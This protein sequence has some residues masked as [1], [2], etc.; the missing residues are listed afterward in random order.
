MNK[1]T[2]QI[3][4][5]RL[6]KKRLIAISLSYSFSFMIALILS[7]I[8]APFVA[9]IVLGILFSLLIIATITL[10]IVMLKKYPK[11]KTKEEIDAEAQE[12]VKHYLESLNNDKN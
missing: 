1:I 12:M 8:F 10:L 2:E 7:I 3:K 11:P 4:N 9:K 6:T 5:K